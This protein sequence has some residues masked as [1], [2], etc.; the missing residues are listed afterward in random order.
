LS[1]PLA[2]H[3]WVRRTPA[4]CRDVCKLFSKGRDREIVRR[5]ALKLRWFPNSGPEGSPA[6]DLDWEWVKQVP[7]PRNIGELRLGSIG[8]HSNLR[9]IFFRGDESVRFLKQGANVQESLPMIWILKVFPKKAND[10][11]TIEISSFRLQ[12]KTVIDEHYT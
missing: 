10:F 3:Y 9:L 5:E 7:G 8:G 12:R 6:I 11:K 2:G 1:G 4:A